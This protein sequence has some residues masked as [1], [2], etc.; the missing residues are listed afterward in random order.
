MT[1]DAAPTDPEDRG[2]DAFSDAFLKLASSLLASP[3]V[4]GAVAVRTAALLTRTIVEHALTQRLRTELPGAE[5]GTLR[6]QL[7]CLRT[8]DERLGEDAG[9]LHG[10]LSGACHHHP[11]D[12][13]PTA[14]EMGMLVERAGDTAGRLLRTDIVGTAAVR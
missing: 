1:A 3:T 2:L 10:E 7:L 11:Y 4:P 13:T 6:S 14:A 5:A 8:L 12:L 9:Q